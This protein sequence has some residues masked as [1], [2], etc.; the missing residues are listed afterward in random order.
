[1]K[2]RHITTGQDSEAPPALADHVRSGDHTP[3]HVPLGEGVRTW[4]RVALLSFG[5]SAGQ[6]AVM[7]RIIVDEKKW[8]G[9]ER[10]LHALAYGMRLLVPELASID[11]GAL[12]IATLACFLTFA[13]KRGMAIT[14]LVSALAGWALYFARTP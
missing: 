4:I 7:H 2:E 13:L 10:F 8:I 14:L 1:M 9:E 12:A 11:F 6:I 5:G 3:V